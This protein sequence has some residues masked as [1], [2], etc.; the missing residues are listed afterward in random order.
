DP[1]VTEADDVRSSVSAEISQE[2]GVLCDSPSLA[3]AEPGQ[4]Q[5]RAASA[6]RRDPHSGVAEADDVGLSV[7]RDVGREAHMVF[8]APAVVVA[9]LSEN[10]CGRGEGAVA[11]AGRGPCAGV[12]EAEDVD[13]T[14]AVH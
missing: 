2:A 7:S 14:I 10:E 4:D 1:G 8:H 11:V 12:A 5:L 6:G 13:T 3:V 9:H